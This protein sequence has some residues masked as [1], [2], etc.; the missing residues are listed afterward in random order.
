LIV[1]PKPIFWAKQEFLFSNYL[2]Q[3]KANMQINHMILWM[4]ELNYNLVLENLIPAEPFQKILIGAFHSTV[5]YDLCPSSNIMPIIEL[6]HLTA[7]RN[8]N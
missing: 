8:S 6:L 1:H 7:K 3:N 4:P 2:L 5:I